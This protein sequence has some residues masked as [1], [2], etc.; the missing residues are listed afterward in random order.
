MND[1]LGE[2]NDDLFDD[3]VGREV[4]MF[5]RPRGSMAP[6]KIVCKCGYL[7]TAMSSWVGKFPCACCG[8]ILLIPDDD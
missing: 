5:R 1:D 8:E 3:Y 4:Q 6:F 2:F 7:T